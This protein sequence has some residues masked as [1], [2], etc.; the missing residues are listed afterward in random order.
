M[1]KVSFGA[2]YGQEITSKHTYM[3][4]ILF[5]HNYLSI[6]IKLVWQYFY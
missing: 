5:K 6:V 3:S 4:A 1:P 2:R